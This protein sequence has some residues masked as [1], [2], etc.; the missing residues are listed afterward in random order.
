MYCRLFTLCLFLSVWYISSL[1][2]S[3]SGKR[4]LTRLSKAFPCNSCRR[5]SRFARSTFNSRLRPAVLSPS[6]IPLNIITILLHG[7]SGAW[8]SCCL[9]IWGSATARCGD[10]PP[11]KSSSDLRPKVHPTESP[12][13]FDRKSNNSAQILHEPKR[14]HVVVFDRD[15]V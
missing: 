14:Y 13:V 3:R 10:A 9:C 4:P 8:H 7:G 11:T 6:A 15:G 2:V 5:Y 12:C 1:S